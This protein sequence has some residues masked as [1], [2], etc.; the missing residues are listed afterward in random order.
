MAASGACADNIVERRATPALSQHWLLSSW[1]V[2]AACCSPAQGT[3]SCGSGTAVQL[4]MPGTRGLVSAPAAS[5]SAPCSSFSW[6]TAGAVS[7]E[8]FNLRPNPAQLSLSIA[9]LVCRLLLAA[10]GADNAA[11]LYVREQGGMCTC[12]CKLRGHTDWVTSVGLLA[13]GAP[14]T[15]DH[16]LQFASAPRLC[17]CHPRHMTTPSCLAP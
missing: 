13:T 14:Q 16:V 15:L 9:V 7:W 3:P 11:R 10:G 5:S 12:A 6:S 4:R 2:V 1:T 17:S 8:C